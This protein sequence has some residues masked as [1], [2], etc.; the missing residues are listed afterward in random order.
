MKPKGDKAVLQ[1]AGTREAGHKTLFCQW[2]NPPFSPRPNECEAVCRGK[3]RGSKGWGAQ[4][5]M[6]TLHPA[7]RG[8]SAPRLGAQAVCR[9]RAMSSE[10]GRLRLRIS[11]ARDLEPRMVARSLACRPPS[12]IRYSIRSIGS[13]SR[14]PS[15]GTHTPR[16][17]RPAPRNDRPPA[18]RGSARCQIGLDLAQGPAIVRSVRIGRT[19]I[20]RS[21]R[22][23]GHTRHG[24]RRT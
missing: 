6:L 20:T 21:L 13:T 3:A 19:S 5:P 17:D 7:D 15:F 18:C 22:L 12:S 2:Q 24:F 9:R 16:S 23:L 4:A 11:E 1:R 10:I 14:S 8:G